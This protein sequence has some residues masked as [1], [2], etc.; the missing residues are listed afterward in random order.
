M[1]SSFDTASMISR[2]VSLSGDTKGYVQLQAFAD[3]L[4]LGIVGGVYA[5]VGATAAMTNSIAI[6]MLITFFIFL[7][8][9]LLFS[10]LPRRSLITSFKPLIK[11]SFRP[12]F[13]NKIELQFHPENAAMALSVFSSPNIFF[14]YSKITI[15]P[16]A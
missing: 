4:S 15:F 3:G 11:L 5:T 7:L 9:H 12:D 2:S 13:P 14:T 10:A 1:N 8:F 16:F 6:N